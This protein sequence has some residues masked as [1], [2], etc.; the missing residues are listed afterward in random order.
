MFKIK[1]FS[2]YE[3]IFKKRKYFIVFD[4][5]FVIGY[6]STVVR[7]LK[8]KTILFAIKM[9]F[10]NWKKS[11]FYGITFAFST[12][13]IVALLNLVY[14]KE[15]LTP[16]GE[17][18]GMVFVLVVILMATMVTFYANSFFLESR[19]KEI[20]VLG[21]G[22]VTVYR[23]GSML[24]IQNLIVIMLSLPVGFGFGV[25]MA[26]ALNHFSNIYHGYTASIY[27]LNS[28]AFVVAA[29]FLVIQ[30][31]YL[32]F[33]NTSYA[34]R[35]EIRELIQLNDQVYKPDNRTMKIP[36]TFYFVTYIAPL[37]WFCFVDRDDLKM[38]VGILSMVGICIGAFGMI[39]YFLPKVI[40]VIKKKFFHSNGVN[41]M[42]AGNIHYAVRSSEL[43]SL[44]ICLCSVGLIMVICSSLENKHMAFTVMASYIVITILLAICIVYKVLV[45]AMKRFKNFRQLQLLG[46]SRKA[47]LKMLSREMVMFYFIIIGT[48]L[49]YVIAILIPNVMDGSIDKSLATFIGGIF[50]AIYVLGGFV[51][52]ITYRVYV[53]NN[54]K[55]GFGDE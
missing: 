16:S 29:V 44:L 12:G 1:L 24:F 48:S 54:L 9:L 22:G 4:I 50:V 3:I 8:M 23:L 47:V 11:V 26:F 42:T 27:T 20:A 43:L 14:N 19:A 5:R 38:T 36:P 45:E 53:M 46:F 18:I 21:L 39:K 52:Y 10:A 55:G 34:F 49:P 37:I 25:G 33:L 6:N 32:A 40:I 31:V 51:S 2:K 28:L 17:P 15:Y 30:L 35:K 13:V 7:R 41:L